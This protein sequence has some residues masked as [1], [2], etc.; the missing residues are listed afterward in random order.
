MILT[1]CALLL[2]DVE[3]IPAK[4]EPCG[5][6]IDLRRLEVDLLAGAMVYSGDFES[7]PQALGLVY[8][9]AP[10]PWLSRYVL[11][12]ECDV[13]G[14]FAQAGAGSIDRDLEPLPDQP[15]GTVGLAAVGMEASLVPEDAW[16][17]RIQGGL[18]YVH[19]GDVDGVDS[20][21]GLLLGINAGAA[22]SDRVWISLLPQAHFGGEDAIFTLSA[23]LSI[24]F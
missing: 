24:R 16:R 10:L 20:G 6:L 9:R 8:L 21:A 3:P 5:A 11:G 15:D 1:L 14:A 7:D 17:L 4:P 19:F 22:L 18:D 12:F 23:G 13:L 2:Q